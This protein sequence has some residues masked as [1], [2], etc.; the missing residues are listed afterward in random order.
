MRRWVGSASP[1]CR[2]YR[3]LHRRFRNRSPVRRLVAFRPHRPSVAPARWRRGARLHWYGCRRFYHGHGPRRRPRRIRPRHF[4]T[5]GRKRRLFRGRQGVGLQ[6]SVGLGSV[7]NG[8]ELVGEQRRRRPRDPRFRHSRRQLRRRRAGREHLH[9]ESSR[10]RRLWV[11]GMDSF[12]LRLHC[13]FDRDG[14]DRRSKNH[15]LA[16]FGQRMRRRVGF[17]LFREYIRGHGH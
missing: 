8:G 5:K 16:L 11:F 9:D 12:G 17:F 3:Q 14:P 7:S 4:R 13:W 15:R 6:H 2:R 10:R 1:V